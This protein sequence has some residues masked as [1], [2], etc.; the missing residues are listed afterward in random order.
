MKFIKRI[1]TLTLIILITGCSNY[2]MTMK[3]GKDKSMEY[4]IMITSN[5]YNNEIASNIS[6]YKE[7]LEPHGYTISEYNTNNQYGIIISKYFENIDTISNGIRSEE[8]NLLYLYTN[9]YNEEIESKMF[10]IAKGIDNNRY[11]ANFY[12]DL[13]QIPN[14]PQNATVTFKV[15]L[16]NTPV[17]SNATNTSEDGKILTWNINHTGKTEIDFVFEL[18]SYD[19]IVYAVSVII[20]VLLFFLIISNLFG[21]SEKEMRKEARKVSS[22]EINNRIQNISN[23]AYQ[24]AGVN[25]AQPVNNPNNNKII[26]SPPVNNNNNIE[27]IPPQIEKNTIT[28]DDI[29]NFKT[30]EK[31]SLFGKK[32]KNNQ[33]NE[34]L[35]NINYNNNIQNNLNNIANNINN[36]SI[37]SSNN[38]QDNSINNNTKDIPVYTS[39]SNSSNNITTPDPFANL[40]E[41]NIQTSK[42]TLETL[43]NIK[44]MES[45]A[46]NINDTNVELNNQDIPLQPTTNNQTTPPQT[47]NNNPVIRVNNK[48][49]VVS[50]TKKEED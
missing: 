46:L 21:K 47:N 1:L 7:K 5:S 26:A 19:F 50:N 24:K 13:S 35:N 16:P 33:E 40:N 44:P 39:E 41:S 34:N 8:Y 28:N 27:I 32:Q 4:S 12:V 2:E 22:T 48:S 31:K 15:E 11:A 25:T 17:S 3:I 29:S 14:I 38:I 23:N 6:F 49:V 10:N 20:V 37:N 18:N 43:A 45:P 42:E 30:P 36:N 9:D